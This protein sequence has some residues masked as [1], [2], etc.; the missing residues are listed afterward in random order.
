MKIFIEP[1]HYV[2]VGTVGELRDMIRDRK[3]E[4][5]VLWDAKE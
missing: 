3:A 4:D 1:N 5:V 2:F